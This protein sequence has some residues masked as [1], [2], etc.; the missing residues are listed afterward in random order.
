MIAENLLL[1]VFAAA[2][3]ALGLLALRFFRRQQQRETAGA[4]RLLA[5]NALVLACLCSVAVLS[6]E[7]YY[8]F[9]FDSTDSFGLTKTNRRWLERHFASNSSGFRD[10]IDYTRRAPPGVRRVTFL[11]DSFTAGHGIADV[12]DRF[13]NRIRALRPD[14]EVHVLASLGWDT[15]PELEIAKLYT[16]QG[17]ETDAIALIYCL[18]DIADIVPEWREILSAIYEQW[19]P[20]WLAANSYLF[21]TLYYRW[22]AARDPALADYYDFVLGAYQ[23]AVWERQQ[24]RLRALR[25]LV[26]AQGAQ[27]LVV[28]FPFVHDLGPDYAYRGVHERLGGFWRAL[29]V[30]HLDLLGVFEAHP[31]EPLAIGPYDA[32]PNERAHAIA[33]DAIAAF[34]DEHLPD[35]NESEAR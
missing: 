14:W 21:N 13:A 35:A 18:N 10:S 28:T 16:E 31:G 11:G 6:G 1:A 22:R 26:D 7:L 15:G 8:R 27:L 2:P 23:G 29:G 20:G 12:E 32:H 3:V 25:E 5:G 34:L 4:A 30:P 24:R 19:R 17:S 33:A 9:W